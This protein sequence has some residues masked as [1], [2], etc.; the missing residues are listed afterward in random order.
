MGLDKGDIECLRWLCDRKTT[1]EK[2]WVRTYRL[3]HPEGLH[4]PNVRSRGCK[5]YDARYEGPGKASGG[6][7]GSVHATE[8]KGTEHPHIHV[9]SECDMG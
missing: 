7:A 6:H 9:V 8:E 4:T 1:A 5:A 2:I 3:V